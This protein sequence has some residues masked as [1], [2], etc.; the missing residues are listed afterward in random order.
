MTDEEISAY[1]L[2]EEQDTQLE[3]ENFRRKEKERG[4]VNNHAL[5]VKI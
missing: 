5:F 2:K 1:C 4:S 3:L